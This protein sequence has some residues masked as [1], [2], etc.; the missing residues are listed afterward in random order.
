MREVLSKPLEAVAP[1][2]GARGVR[3]RRSLVAAARKT[4]DQR[5]SHPA[6]LRLVTDKA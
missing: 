5:G 2:G 1:R 6:E 3:S 4:Q